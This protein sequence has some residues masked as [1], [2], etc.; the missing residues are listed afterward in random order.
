MVLL[1]QRSVVASHRDPPVLPRVDQTNLLAKTFPLLNLSA[2]NWI[3]LDA[4][5]RS[6]HPA[7]RGHSHDDSA[8]GIRA[9]LRLL[10]AG[11]V[12]PFYVL[13]AAAGTWRQIRGVT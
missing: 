13:C 11:R 4:V 10:L 9:A 1:L 6:D 2:V 8:I 7:R 5:C 3:K 12:F